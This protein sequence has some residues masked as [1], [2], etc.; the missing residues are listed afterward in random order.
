[1][2][3]NSFSSVSWQPFRVGIGFAF[4]LVLLVGKEQVLP[5]S[6]EEVYKSTVQSE[7]R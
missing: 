7:C 4:G 2:L 1:M 3:K 5:T 6:M